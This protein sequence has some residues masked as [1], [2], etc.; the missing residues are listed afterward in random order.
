M[1][2]DLMS[3]YQAVAA[4][5]NHQA[6]V[7]EYLRALR[8][9]HRNARGDKALRRDLETRIDHQLGILGQLQAERKDLARRIRVK[10]G[11]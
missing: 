10:K 11:G 5:E 7:Q 8:I 3:L 2:E 1:N 9:A 4:N 6:T